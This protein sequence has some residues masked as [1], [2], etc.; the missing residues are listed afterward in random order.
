MSV[1]WSNVQVT[2]GELQPWSDNPRLST[3]AQAR[4][5]LYSWQ[6]YGQVET[7]ALSPGKDVYNGHQRLSAL[8]TLHGPGYVIDARQCNRYLTEDERRELVILLHAGAVGSWNWDA[9]ANWDAG[10]LQEWGFDS[11]TLT[12]W[13]R[14]VGALGNL[15]ASEEA[16]SADADDVLGDAIE[17]I[18]S[19]M[20]GVQALRGWAVFPS[21]LPMG[22][23]ALRDDMLYSID[24]EIEV[25]HGAKHPIKADSV[26]LYIWSTG[27]PGLDFSRT[28]IGFYT[29]D[30]RFEKFANE[31]DVYVPKLL[32]AGILGALMPNFSMWWEWP[33]VLR[34]WNRYRS[35]WCGRY[36]QE[37]GI[38][39]LPEIQL[40]PADGELCWTGIPAGAD[41]ATQ[42]HTK[43]P[44]S[45]LNAKLAFLHDAI[46]AIKP[47]TVLIYTDKRYV[48]ALQAAGYKTNIQLVLSRLGRIHGEGR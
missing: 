26:L 39:V 18:S 27:K 45:V 30:Y 44:D 21:D 16:D 19:D 23:P 20:P 1:T 5:I 34:L 36:F 47:S 38:Q 22:F 33:Q 35:L 6:K 9:I 2:L 48:D 14:D 10:E 8:L 37:A 43:M 25:W 3:K 42:F 41:F 11:D 17:K 29:E 12:N 13:Q 32:N 40:S 15:L 24:R 7:V 28:L 31:P 46:E 4:K